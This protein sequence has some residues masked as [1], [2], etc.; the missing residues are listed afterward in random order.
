MTDY[1]SFAKLAVEFFKNAFSRTYPDADNRVNHV[2]D[3]N[4]SN[5]YEIGLL[6]IFQTN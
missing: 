4:L 5:S 1:S 3:N 2:E 6:C